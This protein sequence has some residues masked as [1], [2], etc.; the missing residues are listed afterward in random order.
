[1]LYQ[2]D[3][4]GKDLL[5]GFTEGIKGSGISIVAQESYEATDPTVAPQVKK[6]AA[7]K[8]DTFLDI[9]T[10]K[11]GAQAIATV[12]QTG[13]KPLHILNSVAA[14]KAQVLKPVGFQYAQGIVT[15]SYFKAL[16]DPRWA[17][18]QAV[19]D[20]L[21]DLK[22]Y[23]PD[24]DPT[25]P[26]TVYGWL[27]GETIVQ[28]LQKMSSPTRDALV[29]AAKHLDYTSGLLLPGITVKTD[30]DE[31][32]VPD[33]GHADRPVHRSGLRA[34]GIGDPGVVGPDA[35]S[36]AASLADRVGISAPTHGGLLPKGLERC[37]LSPVRW[38]SHSR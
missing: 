15:A 18:D 12:A 20:L 6:L 21:A 7:S 17:N 5:G 24:A 31:R 28:A 36:L 13:W 1:M 11:A 10:P 35:S 8:A 33:R 34:E 3:G 32:P 29:D 37:S 23:A 26:Y 25:D 14:S 4:F 27:V 22:K 9:T 2:N 38:S 16:D 30:G 19:K